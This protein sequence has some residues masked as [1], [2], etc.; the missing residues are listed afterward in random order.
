MARPKITVL[1]SVYNAEK[2]LREAID[3]I[4]AQTFA[5]FEFVIYDDC[6]T[7][8]SR[9][10][11]Q[12]Y[13]DPRI[14]LRCNKVNRGLTK[15]LEEGMCLAKGDFVARMDADDI[16]NPVRFA[17]QLKYF[18]EH[19]EVAILGTQVE[20]FDD[21]RKILC[22]TFE[23]ESH[24]DI[25]ARL[26]ISF[27]LYHPTIMFRMSVIRRHQLNY[28]PSFRYA[29][30]HDL[31][32]RAMMTVRL[33]NHPNVLMKMRAHATSVSRVKYGPQQVCADRGRKEMLD[34]CGIS[35]SSE[36]LN[37]YNYIAKGA[38]AEIDAHILATFICFSKR[39]LDNIPNHYIFD[40][41]KLGR[42]LAIKVHGCAYQMLRLRLNRDGMRLYYSSGLSC[43]VPSE[44]WKYRLKIFFLL[45][46]S[47]I[48]SALRGRF[49]QRLTN[50]L[51]TKV[52]YCLYVKI[53]PILHRRLYYENIVKGVPQ[54][55]RYVLLVELNSYHG[56][57]LV[58]IHQLLC[59]MGF[60]VFVLANEALIRRFGSP[61][62]RI[63]DARVRFLPVS[64]ILYLLQMDLINRFEFVF[65]T[66][67]IVN[68]KDYGLYRTFNNMFQS[69]RMSRLGYIALVHNVDDT[70][71]HME[72]LKHGRYAALNDWKE[73][74]EFPMIAPVSF[75][76][77]M[78]PY[79]QNK[80][81]RFVTV[82]RFEPLIRDCAILERFIRQ[83]DPN[84]QFE[85][86]VLGS[87]DE[88]VRERFM[89]K[90]IIF[91]GCVS[92]ENM[93]TICSSCDFI[94][95][96][97]NDS[98]KEHKQYRC[99]TTTGSRQLMLAFGLIP[100][101]QVPFAEAYHLS[102]KNALIYE[103]DDMKSEMMEAIKMS[104]SRMLQMRCEIAN[105]KKKIVNASQ[106]N[107]QQLLV[108]LAK[109]A[110]V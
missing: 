34:R 44:K 90:R 29:Q 76:L 101:L 10:I 58:G 62:C 104:E 49:F 99:S 92:F 69:R 8:Q 33:A 88:V 12:G 28:D 87:T 38:F 95:P 39:I 30:D 75:G 66:T 26:F 106:K 40:R 43:Y 46:C 51:R 21:D 15:N 93:Y 110:R 42:Q 74:K 22:R 17:E 48:Q 9:E 20:F 70:M 54:N 83:V 64:E 45:Q 86:H 11:I 50:K 27:S 47:R 63:P 6:S 24:E 82:G 72:S 94:L 2:Y 67:W 89:D 61:F 3:S 109:N 14:I 97:L 5:D 37:S 41:G 65:V 35:Y 31:W 52:A 91:H 108:E 25:T 1:M 85:I 78:R 102:N 103:G 96:L 55:V 105:L 53:L 98:I 7:D 68:L 60:S 18:D 32:F 4:L 57:V 80:I 16:A 13:S 73:R 19:P 100:V 56:E 23:P 79:V 84:E 81:K 59:S 107:L 71:A 77:D 36:E